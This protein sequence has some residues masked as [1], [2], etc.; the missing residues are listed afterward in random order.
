MVHIIGFHVQDTLRRQTIM[1]Q[2][3]AVVVGGWAGGQGD[4]KG[5]Q[6]GALGSDGA[7]L[8]S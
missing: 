3:G 1:I 2:N 5:E 4:H 8:V 7:V 6:M